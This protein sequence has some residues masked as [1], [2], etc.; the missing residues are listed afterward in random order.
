M[1]VINNNT[2]IHYSEYLFKY[3]KK[4]WL[5]MCHVNKNFFSY[6]IYNVLHVKDQE[7]ICIDHNFLPSLKIQFFVYRQYCDTVYFK[8]KNRLFP[9]ISQLIAINISGTFK[10]KLL[11]LI[12]GTQDYLTLIEYACLKNNADLVQF[13][14]PYNTDKSYQNCMHHAIMNDNTNLVRFLEPLNSGYYFTCMSPIKSQHSD[15]LKLAIC[16]N[17]TEIFE[18]LQPLKIYQ[19]YF[20]QILPMLNSKFNISGT[21]TV[22]CEDL[23]IVCSVC[24]NYS[25]NNHVEIYYNFVSEHYNFCYISVKYSNK[26]LNNFKYK[27]VYSTSTRFIGNLNVVLQDICI[28]DHQLH[29]CDKLQDQE[30][31]LLTWK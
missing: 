17:N 15:L 10:I 27:Y 25:V 29:Y 3:H 30:P 31:L 8:L 22:S 7:S 18:L 14:E 4:I 13:V 20:Y 23:Q 11:V 9:N 26:I 2:L 1:D 16:K 28:Y 5:T 24:L 6:A 19:V 12:M 21:W